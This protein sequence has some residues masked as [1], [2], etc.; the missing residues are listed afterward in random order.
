MYTDVCRCPLRALA[1]EHLRDGF[2]RGAMA[3]RAWAKGRQRRTTSA[4]AFSDGK[5]CQPRTRLNA[6]QN[7]V[8]R[9]GLSWGSVFPTIKE[10]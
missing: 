5:R 7:A 10:M 2:V 1:P 8:Q 4:A 3:T 6:D 9:C